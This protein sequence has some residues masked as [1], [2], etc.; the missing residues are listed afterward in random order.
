M[1]RGLDVDDVP[2]DIEDEFASPPRI[3][4]S[5]NVMAGSNPGASGKTS[6]PSDAD[7]AQQLADIG[8]DFFSSPE[9]EITGQRLV[10]PL[11]N[12]RQTTLFGQKAVQS[13]IPA[14]QAN[15]VRQYRVDRPPE[16]PTHHKI[17]LE[18]M[19]TWVYPTNLGEIRDYQYSIVKTGLFSNTLVALPTGLGKTFIAATIMLNFY[20]WTTDAQ[21][22]FMAP[23]KPLVTQQVNACFNV[24]GI[25]R[26]ATTMLNGEVKIDLREEAWAEKRVFF[27]TPQTLE[28]DLARGLADPKRIAL[29]VIDEA[30]RATGKYSYVKCVERIRAFNKSFR[31]LALTATPGSNVEK[32]QE[33][34]DGLEIAKIEIRTEASIDIQPFVHRRNIDEIVLE[35]SD[36]MN[37]ITDLFS[38]AIQPLVNI[39]C[40]Q[41]AYYNRDPMSLTPFGLLK[42]QKEWFASPAGRGASDGVKMQMRA[43]ITILSSIAHSIKLLKFH[44]MTPFYANMKAFR[45]QVDDKGEKGSKYKKQIVNSGDFKDMM[46]HLQ[47]WTANDDFIGHPKITVLCDTILNHFTDAGEG[48]DAAKSSTRVMVFSEFRDSAEVIVTELRKYRPMIKPSM[49]VGQADSG[50]SAGMKQSK[51]SEVIADFKKGNFN[52]LVATS[53]GEEG[54]DIGEVDLIICYDTSAS[55]IRMLQRMGRTGRKRAGRIVCLMMKGK[56]HE[57]FA[58]A[59]DNYE[60][61]QQLISNGS[62]FGFRDDLSTRIVPRDIHPEVDKRDVEIPFENTQNPSL[63]VPKAKPRGVVKKKTVKKFHMPDGVVTGFQKASKI[64]EGGATAGTKAR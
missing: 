3:T 9:P 4:V 49:F 63:P 35:P 56:E 27:V 41:K 5:S 33:V 25:P 6:R 11:N 22:V 12:L 46:N 1:S 39:L 23:T 18:A 24:A 58:K 45:E 37:E 26:S 14:S 64:V 21:I 8:S 40:G 48:T 17:D 36:E 32:V 16:T 60:K 52:V 10:A 2:S 28:N 53:I 31:V 34:I 29:M 51:Q 13:Q 61:M 54:L 44:G 30:H 55:P 7:L 59:K 20:R 15:M 50:R 47:R 57:N 62:Q 43:V 42:S 19:K 38:K